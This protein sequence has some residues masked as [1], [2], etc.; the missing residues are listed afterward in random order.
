MDIAIRLLQVSQD[1]N[2]TSSIL[3]FQPTLSHH[4]KVI[5][6]KA[7]N[8]KLRGTAEDTWKLN[9]FCKYVLYNRYKIE[10]HTNDQW[11]SKIFWQ[12]PIRTALTR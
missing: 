4:D 2:M 8:L 3:S 11:K 10:L 9:V 1:G 12:F 6:C 5:T 7:E